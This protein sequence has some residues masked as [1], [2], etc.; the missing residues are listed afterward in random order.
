MPYHTLSL[1]LSYF[2]IMS[3]W[4]EFGELVCNMTVGR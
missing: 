3:H 1:P 4:K 2:I